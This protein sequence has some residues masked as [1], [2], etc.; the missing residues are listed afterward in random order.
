[1]H[2][3]QTAQDQNQAGHQA[4]PTPEPATDVMASIIMLKRLALSILQTLESQQ[5]QATV[6]RP[7]PARPPSFA[8]VQGY[9][10]QQVPVP[11]MILD[12]SSHN[13][14]TLSHTAVL[15]QP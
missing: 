12:Q 10:A 7:Q 4:R 14:S 5:F 2:S 6:P 3:N 15:R 11:Q 8:P 1:M 13:M 9:Y